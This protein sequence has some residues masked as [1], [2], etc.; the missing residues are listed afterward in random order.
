MY[1][2]TIL[3]IIFLQNDPVIYMCCLPV[4]YVCLIGCVLPGK[5]PQL[6]CQYETAKYL[7]VT[8]N[9]NLFI[10]SSLQAYMKPNLFQEIK[11]I[12]LSEH[13]QK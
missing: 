3:H 9:A 12:H 5:W 11:Q 2:N 7:I 10:Y 6:F 1:Y 13:V 8:Y 4:C